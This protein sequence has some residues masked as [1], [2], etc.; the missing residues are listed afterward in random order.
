MVLYAEPGLPGTENGSVAVGDVAEEYLESVRATWMA[1][2]LL[3]MFRKD[4]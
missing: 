2:S 3:V 4:G 1:V